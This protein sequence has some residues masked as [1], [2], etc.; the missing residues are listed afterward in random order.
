MFIFATDDIWGALWSQ[1][2]SHLLPT[3]WFE[4]IQVSQIDH[5]RLPSWHDVAHINVGFN[6]KNNLIYNNYVRK[7]MDEQ[8]NVRKYRRRGNQKWIIQRNRQHRVHKAK[9]KHN[10][11]CVGHHYTQTNTNSVNKTRALLQTTGGKGEPSIV[12]MRKS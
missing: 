9:Q 11:I 12:F 8:I 5:F 2:N 10:T 3:F 4:F 6:F 7:S 1:S